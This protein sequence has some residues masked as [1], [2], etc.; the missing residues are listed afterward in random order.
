MKAKMILGVLFIFSHYF[1]S[2]T[3]PTTKS[4]QRYL[5]KMYEF[6]KENYITYISF[7]DAK[8]LRSP[9]AEKNKGEK[10]R[11]RIIPIKPGINDQYIESYQD[12]YDFLISRDGKNI[13]QTRSESL[14][15]SEEIEIAI[16]AETQED[17]LIICENTIRS[18]TLI[19]AYIAFIN[20]I[21]IN[22]NALLFKHQVEKKDSIPF[23]KILNTKEI[24]DNS[25]D[26]LFSIRE[27]FY[28]NSRHFLY[29]RGRSYLNYWDPYNL[30]YQTNDLLKNF[31]K[32][33]EL[34]HKNPF[35][36]SALGLS[37]LAFAAYSKNTNYQFF[38]NDQG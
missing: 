11:L 3:N 10:K 14:Y 15:C 5:P 18:L 27:K 16:E 23:N 36:F 21:E 4:K 1:L 9:H 7:D 22:E 20:N 33:L 25:K 8:N 30:S 13:F 37:I 19:S 29:T 35:Y 38:Y 32:S 31:N 28:L 17:N 6:L 24:L 2:A 12:D 26:L 34:F